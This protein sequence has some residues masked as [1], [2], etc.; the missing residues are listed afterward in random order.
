MTEGTSLVEVGNPADLLCEDSMPPA[1]FVKE[2]KAAERFWDFFTANIRNRH[3]RRAYYNG[4]CKF[5]EFCA[6]RGVHDLAYVKP[7]HVAGYV[8]SLRD[9]FAKPTIKQHLAAIRMMLDWLVVGQIIDSNPAHAVRGPKHVVTKG[10]TPVLNREEARALIASIDTS[11]LTGLRDRAL[12]AVMIYTFARVGAVLQMNVGD[13]FS[14][15]RRGWIRLHEKGGKEHEAPCVPKLE[16]YLDAYIAAAGIGND[17]DGPLFR[18]TGRF[19]GVPHRMTQQDGYRMIAR[20][21]RQ[22][23]IKTRIGNH[24]MRATGITDYLKSDGTLEHAQTMAAHSSPRTTK[25]YDRRNE[26]TELGEYEKVRI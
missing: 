4:I 14:Q 23:G 15:G 11:T 20:R 2:A 24:S 13:Y 1:L 16:V 17:R 25:L 10:R 8:E 3:T 12:I 19:T 22:A 7:I 6:E 26:E 21:A 5:A 18:T 9:N